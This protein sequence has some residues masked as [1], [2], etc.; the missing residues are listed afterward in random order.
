MIVEVTLAGPRHAIIRI[1]RPQVVQLLGMGYIE[2]S[3]TAWC[4]HFDG[5]PPSVVWCSVEIHGSR[6]L[7]ERET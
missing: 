5:D 6:A 3:I 1:G 2:N 4:T 7:E